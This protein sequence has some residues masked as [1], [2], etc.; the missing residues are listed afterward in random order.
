MRD[1]NLSKFVHIGFYEQVWFAQRVDSLLRQAKQIIRKTE[2]LFKQK[3]IRV[4]LSQN[5]RQ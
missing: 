2:M 5:Q 1:V 4:T 3:K